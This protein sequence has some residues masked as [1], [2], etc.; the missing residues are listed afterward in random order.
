MPAYRDALRKAD[1]LAIK[2][3]PH[4]CAVL[5]DLRKPARES[6]R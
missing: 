5:D 1:A 2:D 4:L 3:L 6:K